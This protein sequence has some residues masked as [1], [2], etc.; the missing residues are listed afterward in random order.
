MRTMIQRK[1]ANAYVLMGQYDE[2]MPLFA[3]VVEFHRKMV[4]IDPQDL[5]ALADLEVILDDEAIGLET[6]ADPALASA[7]S[8]SKNERVRFLAQSCDIQREVIGIMDKMLKQDPTNENWKFVRA[9][10]Q[11]GLATDESS[12]NEVKGGQQSQDAE[13]L[14]RAGLATYRE[15]AQSKEASAMVLAS[16]S[17]AFATVQPASLRD[18]RYAVACA[19]RAVDES[20]RQRPALLLTLAQALHAAGQVDEARLVAKEGLALLPSQQAGAARSNIRKQLEFEAQ[21]GPA[22]VGKAS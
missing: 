16:A 20:H 11:V 4:A 2:A 5:R 12:L 14:A 15:L 7:K 21:A 10:A 17:T 22:V 18:P 9:S 13:G 19:E 3:Q 6:A 1:T 8:G